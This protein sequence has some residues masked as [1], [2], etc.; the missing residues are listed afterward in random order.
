M[1]DILLIRNILDAATVHTM[2]AELRGAS[3]GPAVV[4]GTAASGAV[5]SR[6]RKVTRIALSPDARARL[7]RQ[8]MDHR[9]ELDD[10]FG[11]S[12]TSCEDPQVLRYETGDFFVAHQDGNTPLVYDDSRFRRV[13]VVIFLSRQSVEPEPGTYG[14][15]ELVLHGSAHTGDAPIRLAP[16]PGTLVA[17][18]SETTHEV[19]PV[20]HGERYTIVSW[21]R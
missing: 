12:L 18:R 6:V 10:H 2:V 17:F 13:S 7:T 16:E 11:L 15:G 14:G 4:Y 20:V 3:G 21:F 5:E 19:V 8:L 9:G 1:I